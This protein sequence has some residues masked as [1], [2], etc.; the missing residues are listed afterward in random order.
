MHPGVLS[1]IEM[2]ISICKMYGVRTSICGQAGSRPEMAKFLVKKGISSIS[3]N[4]DS[5]QLIR[6]AVEE[7]SQ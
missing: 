5:V 1:L 3:A 2:V 6:D 7:F 4:I